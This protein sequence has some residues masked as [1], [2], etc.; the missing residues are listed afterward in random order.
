M[1]HLH[2]DNMKAAYGIQEMS[3]VLYEVCTK[4]E[5]SGSRIRKRRRGRWPE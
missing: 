4:P 3:N 5:R 1:T 2:V